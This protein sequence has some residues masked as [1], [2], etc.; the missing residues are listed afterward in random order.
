MVQ[1]T[2]VADNSHSTI[3]FAVKHM[4]ISTVK[5]TFNDFEAKLT[6]DIED[7]T[8]VDLDVL[9]D[10]N[11]IDTRNKERD[12]HLRSA[13]FFDVEKHPN[14]TFKST[15]INKKSDHEYDVVGDL[16]IMGTTKQV[17]FDLTYGGKNTN[18]WGKEVIAISAH[19]SINR[20][21]YGLT[22]NAALE[23]GGVL[24]SEN[25]NINIEMQAL[26]EN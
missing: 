15:S 10:V 23:T 16:T 8:T 9:I 19:T 5:G 17:T 21:D 4:M 25:V 12:D 24:V 1:T 18:P 26:Q 7:L 3:E 13:D 14:I 20:K 6:G 11:S 22:W 2:W